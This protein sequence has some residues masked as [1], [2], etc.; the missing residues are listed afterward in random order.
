MTSARRGAQGGVVDTSECE[1]IF[2]L[3]NDLKTSERSLLGQ[4]NLR[5]LMIWHMEGKEL[6]CSQVPVMAILKE[7]RAL[8]GING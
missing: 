8:A 2:S 3:M 4:E 7:F 1:R 6:P 5:S